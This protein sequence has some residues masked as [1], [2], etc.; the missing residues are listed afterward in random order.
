[1]KFLMT[2]DSDPELARHGETFARATGSIGFNETIQTPNGKVIAHAIGWREDNVPT[3]V[4][5]VL[6]DVPR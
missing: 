6:I 1:M 2:I 5:R 3:T 4:T